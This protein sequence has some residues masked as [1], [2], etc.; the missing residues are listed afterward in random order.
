[1]AD[2]LDSI[3]ESFN[4]VKD[5]LNTFVFTGKENIAQRI[6]CN[7]AMKDLIAGNLK[8]NDSEQAE[9]KRALNGIK[10]INKI[11]GGK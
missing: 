2:T 6:K 7:S 9:I 11:T 10:Q 1:M 5:R 4:S 8:A 3:F